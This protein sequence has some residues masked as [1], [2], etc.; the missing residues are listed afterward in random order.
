MP[1]HQKHRSGDGWVVI[2]VR[3]EWTL[4][5]NSEYRD[6]LPPPGLEDFH[7]ATEEEADEEILRRMRATSKA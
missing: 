6:L 1:S 4:P 7:C 2:T 5:P 3:D